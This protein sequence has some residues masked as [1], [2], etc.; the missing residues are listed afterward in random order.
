MGMSSAV[1]EATTCL[2]AEWYTD[3]GPRKFPPVL[4]RLAALTHL[5]FGTQ[6]PAGDAARA[7]Y[8]VFGELPAE[9]F[10]RLC[11]LQFLQLFNCTVTSCPAEISLLTG[12]W[13]TPE[14]APYSALIAT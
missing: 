2:L 12:R 13:G 1:F 11:R 3:E 10:Q 7:Q 6:R 5:S 4:L 8:F 14:V 9:L